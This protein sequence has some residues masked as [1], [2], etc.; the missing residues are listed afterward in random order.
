MNK[1]SRSNTPLALSVAN[2]TA[3]G[4]VR[5]TT[6]RMLEFDNAR[7][8]FTHAYTWGAM[9]VARRGVFKPDCSHLVYPNTHSRVEA[10]IRALFE[11][12]QREPV[13]TKRFT[14]FPQS[15]LTTNRKIEWAPGIEINVK[16][17]CWFVKNGLPIIPLLQPRKSALPEESL[18]FYATLG[19]QA[20]CNGDWVG[21]RIEIVDISGADGVYASVIGHSDLIALPDSRVSQFVSTYLEAKK[22]VDKVRS[23]RPRKPQKAPEPDLYDLPN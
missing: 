19:R 14:D 8:G 13:D 22:I 15:G 23:E 11:L 7:I 17:N 4:D 18:A 3:P 12:G 20:F 16:A 9:P 5:L 6:E 21:A 1:P 10:C 2:V